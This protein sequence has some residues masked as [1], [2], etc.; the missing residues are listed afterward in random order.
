MHQGRVSDPPLMHIIPL[1]HMISPIR[2][3]QIE[4][5]GIKKEIELEKNHD[6]L[7]PSPLH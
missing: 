3:N 4:R 1:M 7:V 2:K 5:P 6:H